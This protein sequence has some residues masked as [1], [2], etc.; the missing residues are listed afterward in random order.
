MK[1]LLL[2][3]LFSSFLLT[4]LAQSR[5]YISVRKKNGRV[6]KNFYSGSDILL[7][8]ID[9][10]YLHGPIKTVRHDSVFLTLYD[11]RYFPTM[12]GGYIKDTIS[13]MVMGLP[14]KEIKRIML[15][16][17]TSFAGRRLGPILMIAGAG[18]FTLNVINGL[19]DG[20][21]ITESN[22]LQKLGIA[23]ALFGLGYFIK[24]LTYSDG[25]SKPKHS[26]VYVKLEPDKLPF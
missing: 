19:A 24:R 1:P 9:N 7:Q 3:L 4:S 14:F 15:N 5:D 20:L 10:S 18:Y 25:F 11:I 2:S 13:T 8:T 12:Y 22:N 17:K 26:I 16:T 21:P 6:L 23:G